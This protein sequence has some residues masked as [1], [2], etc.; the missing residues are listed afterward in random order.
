MQL[1]LIQI[2]D[3]NKRQFTEDNAKYTFYADFPEFTLS[4][5]IGACNVS[6]GSKKKKRKT[7]KSNKKRKAS[8]RT[9][10]R[11]YR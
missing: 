3:I 9:R 10:A 11:K 2:L 5:A 8:A 4:G 7:K 1:L 6:G